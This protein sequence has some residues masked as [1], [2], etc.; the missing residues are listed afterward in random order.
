MKSASYETTAAAGKNSSRNSF[1]REIKASN[2][3]LEDEEVDLLSIIK[4]QLK[5]PIEMESTD[6]ELAKIS[7]FETGSNYQ[8]MFQSSLHGKN[9]FILFS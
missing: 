7:L 1:F 6:I 4:Q 3:S 9:Y 8:H 2:L 5:L